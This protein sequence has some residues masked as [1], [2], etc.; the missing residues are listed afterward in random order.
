ME[1]SLRLRQ[2]LRVLAAVSVA[3][4]GG[5]LGFHW[6]LDESWFQSFY[7]S[8]VTTT[9]AGLDTVPASDGARLL[10]IA[11]VICGLTIIAYAGA[12]IV[13]VIAGGVL[14]GVLAERRRERTI[15]RLRDHF[16]ICGYGRVGRRVAEEFRVSGERYVVLD[17]REDAVAAAKEHGD[18]LIEGDATEDED[19][20]RA[21]IEHAKGLVAASDSDADNLYIAL[22][23]RSV[24]PDIQIV[25]RASDEDAE[26]KLKLAGADRVVLP[27]ATAGRTMA[28]LVLKPQVTAFLDAV[29][30]ATGPDLHM[31]EIEMPAS[32]VHAGKTI[33]EIRVRHETG[34]IIVALRKRDGTFDTTPEPDVRIDP[35]D[36]LVGVGTAEELRRLEDL[37]ASAEH[38]GS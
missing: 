24:R 17:Y 5:T 36:V 9:L 10:S 28:N 4:A 25:A 2:T 38:R 16:I 30:T 11:L 15:E 21:G 18:L 23:A 1:T 12:V 37:F 19:L 35:G 26:K 32:C 13:E 34:A 7:R 31:A 20:R 6:L 3:L 29:T 27:Y 22:S 33:R 8:V 14:T